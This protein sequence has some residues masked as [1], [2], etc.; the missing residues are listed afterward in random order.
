MRFEKILLC[1]ILAAQVVLVSCERK[2][3]SI[4]KTMLENRIFDSVGLLSSEEKNQLFSLIQDLEETIGPQ[5]A[6]VIIDTLNGEKIEQF[7]ILTAEKLQLGRDRFKDGVLIAY[8]QK[9]A[10]V[11][12]EVGYGLE[13]I[14]RDEIAAQLLR[15]R[16]IP[17]FKEN[18]FFEG[19]YSTIKEIMILIEENKELVGKSY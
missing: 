10:K 17:K 4:N 1:G 9:D 6:V 5:I 19:L 12:I 13:R 16:L 7:S 18:Q 3:N 2:T 15:E 14:I 8:A 11:R